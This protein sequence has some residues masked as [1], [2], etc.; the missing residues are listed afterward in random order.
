M[1]HDHDD[2]FNNYLLSALPQDDWQAI[3]PYLELVRLSA[4]QVLYDAGEIIKSVYFPTTAIV[5]MLCLLEDGATVEVAAVGAEGMVG[6][7]VLMGGGT[8]P[9]RVEVRNEG[10]AYAMRVHRFEHVYE[11]GGNLHRIML[12]Y[13]QAL[14]TQIAQSAL[15]NR[16]HSI[17]EQLCCWLLHTKDRLRSSELNV[18]QQLIASMLGVRREGVTE[19]ARKLQEAGLIRCRRGHITVLDHEGLEQHA[20]ECY[21]IVKGEFTRLLS[22]QTKP[23]D[24]RTW[25][26]SPVRANAHSLCAG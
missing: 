24:T 6:V 8:M 4:G 11:P 7:P 3:E 13:V 22:Q 16:R 15:C 1:F 19:A 5:S 25:S 14:M 20:C 26:T 21:G 23:A 9:C 17:T 12:L 18:T 10:W 2:H